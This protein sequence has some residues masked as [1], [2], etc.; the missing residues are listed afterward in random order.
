MKILIKMIACGCFCF[1]FFSGICFGELYISKKGYFKIDVPKDWQWSDQAESVIISG[2]EDD[3]VIIIKAQPQ[4]DVLPAGARMED[5][6]EKGIEKMIQK[7]KLE[8][9]I[10]VSKK[11]RSLDGS[12]AQ[13]V[14]F[15]SAAGENKAHATFIALFANG[16][17]FSIYMEGSDEMRRTTME[18]I[19]DTIRFLGD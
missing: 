2:R 1:L 5:V 16:H 12:P 10:I 19:V 8:K 9:G 18:K 6:L 13:Q 4:A 15:L 7:V 11:A 3:G 14:N 17:F